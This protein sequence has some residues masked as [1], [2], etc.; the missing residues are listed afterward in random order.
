[1]SE[2]GM[3]VEEF[4]KYF[5]ALNEVRPFPWQRRL[6][7]QLFEG[8]DLPT[9]IALPT[10]T[11]K[12]A[13]L[14][15]AVFCLAAQAGNEKR[16]VGRR[17]F[18]V[19][20]RRLI[21]DEV[22]E[23][24]ERIA[25]KL[26]DALERNDGGILSKV[27][28]KLKEYGGESPLETV[29][30][31]GAMYR[32]ED[33]ADSPV[34]PLIVVSTVDQIGSRLLFRGYGLSARTR[35]IH[36]ALIANDSLIIL[37]EAHISL[38]FS[39]TVQAVE[40]YRGEAWA[41]VP[42]G[43]PFKLVTMSAT[44]SSHDFSLSKEDEKDQELG[45]RLKA[46]RTIS[47]HRVEDDEFEAEVTKLAM[48][49]DGDAVVAVVLNTV[50]AA[51]NVFMRLQNH[52][53]KA[54][55]LTGRSRPYDRDLLM[56]EI[57][58]QIEA[59][60]R[61]EKV[62]GHLIVVATQ[63][64][65]VGADFDFDAMVTECASLDALIQRLGRV[66]RFGRND[67]SRV[68]IVVRE[69]QTKGPDWLYGEALKKT[70]AWFHKKGKQFDFCPAALEIPRELAMEQ[71]HAPVMLPVYLDSWVQTNP[72]PNFEPSVALFLHGQESDAEVQL[73]WRTDLD[74]ENS[75]LWIDT[76]SLFPPR[77]R[78][79]I[80]VPMSA[81][82]S[83]L[84][85]QPT[86]FVSD[87]EGEPSMP[88]QIANGKK[89]LRWNGPKKFRWNGS[90]ESEV[91]QPADIQPGDTLV[92]PAVY[93]GADKY[94]WNPDSKEPVP[95]VAEHVSFET[96]YPTLRL[97]KSV[98]KNWFENEE[99]AGSFMQKVEEL[100]NE[101]DEADVKNLLEYLSDNKVAANEVVSGIAASLL[102]EKKINFS[103]YP[104]GD[105]LVIKGTRRPGWDEDDSSFSPRPVTLLDH[106]KGVQDTANKFATAIG[107]SNAL[108]QDIGLAA[109]LHDAGKAD[110]RFQV[111]LHNGDKMAA[112]K[113]KELLAKSGMGSDRKARELAR[114]RSG[115]PKGARHEGLSVSMIA[116]SGAVREQAKD[117]DLVLHLVASH[118]GYSRPFFPVLEDQPL[119]TCLTLGEFRLSGSTDHGLWRLDSGV[120]DRFWILT[121]RYGYYG[122]AFLEAVLR[123]ADH[124]RS[125][126]E[127][128]KMETD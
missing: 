123:L 13:V 118:H 92:M 116:N 97:H 75:D 105:G 43:L 34:Q 59:R 101:P 126:D 10:A 106:S 66:N 83:W 89:V 44:S 58:P 103:Q 125:A 45:K 74:P 104:S 11:G 51:R 17:I 61:G 36:A 8:A 109:F 5:E 121:R 14:D 7:S 6:A 98:M 110:R 72:S 63:C 70:W 41:G 67:V 96:G 99:S 54:V 46:R 15:I 42:L 20:D 124:R 24:A 80:P 3:S 47:L 55:L 100:P 19:V 33:W 94:G 60:K 122:L 68:D 85:S 62:E 9:T 1:M 28:K 65:E 91:I 52:A 50:S 78:E 93:G 88:H 69:K 49:H 120:S 35:P 56:R 37:D 113:A 12:T 77:V 4:E 26:H 76:V 95:D 21:V 31:R 18:Y 119:E 23:R 25:D 53:V 128:R 102:K 87:L 107:L 29:R 57:G 79:A 71:K 81:V 39:E 64:I 40:R 114:E 38:P 48:M 84:A 117:F 111:L 27:A 112:R 90:K 82:K 108:L 16:T 127:E 115:Y 32:D 73:V 30:L 86:K 22:Y 2:M